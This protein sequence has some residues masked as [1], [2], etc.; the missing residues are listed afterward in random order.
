MSL[1]E[2]HTIPTTINWPKGTNTNFLI[3]PVPNVTPV[4]IDRALEFICGNCIYYDKEHTKK[5]LFVLPG[6]TDSKKVLSKPITMEALFQE[7][8]GKCADDKDQ[9][10]Y[11]R[12]QSHPSRQSS[13]LKSDAISTIVTMTQNVINTQVEGYVMNKLSV[14]VSLPFGHPQGI[15][16]DDFRSQGDINSDG[17]MLS[18]I[19]ALQN[20]TRLDIGTSYDHSMTYTIPS[21]SMFLLSGKCWH[22]GSA[23]MTANIR[24]HMTFIPGSMSKKK[25]ARDNLIPVGLRCPVLDCVS[26][27]VRKQTFT[28]EQL[29]NHWRLRHRNT[30]HISLGK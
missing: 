9:L 29:Y 23:Y 13:L 25:S 18:V 7:A 11:H 2:P 27:C 24:L 30:Y 16:V 4:V 19:F 8:V 26:N 6:I 17:E 20:G 5:T 12:L 3:L 10:D 1:Q 14:L 15:H 22:R 28:K 21:A